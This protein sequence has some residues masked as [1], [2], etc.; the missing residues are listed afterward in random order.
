MQEALYTAESNLYDD[1]TFNNLPDKLNEMNMSSVAQ[2]S[3][4][5]IHKL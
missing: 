3:G 1:I 2:I 4:M 5:N